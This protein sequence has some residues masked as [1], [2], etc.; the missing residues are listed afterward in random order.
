MS[1]YL[2][3]MSHQSLAM[4]PIVSPQISRR[5]PEVPGRAAWLVG[6]GAESDSALFCGQLLDYRCFCA[7]HNL[8][9]AISANPA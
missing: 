3:G 9:F 5:I 4:G 7:Y 2:P 1:P 6:C 8:A